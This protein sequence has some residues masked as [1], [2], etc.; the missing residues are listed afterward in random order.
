MKVLTFR[1]GQ[2]AVIALL[3]TVLFR[4]VLHLCVGMEG[5]VEPI[6]CA[7]VYFCLMFLLG[8]Y[9][10]EKDYTENDIHDIGF[11][12]H[13]TT[14]IICIGLAYVAYYIGWGTGNVNSITIT[15]ICWGIGLFIHFVFFLI[16]QKKT[17]KGYAKEELFQ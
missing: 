5:A 11:R 13:L 4:Y 14:Y 9:L 17:I 3:L 6:L 2:F 8:W 15:S 12:F 10:G 7:V 16:E 1:L